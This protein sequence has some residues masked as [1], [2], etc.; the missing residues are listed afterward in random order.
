MWLEINESIW[1]VKLQEKFSSK[2]LST[3]Y[4]DE[5]FVWGILNILNWN[6]LNPSSLQ[7]QLAKAREEYRKTI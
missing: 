2:I 7:E 5:S 1:D 3:I 4:R 6:T